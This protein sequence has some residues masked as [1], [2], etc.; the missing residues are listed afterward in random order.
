MLRR[1]QEKFNEDQRF[2]K[3]TY[4][5]TLKEFK[6]IQDSLIAETQ[7]NRGQNETSTL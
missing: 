2:L 1:R 5:K 4:E 7:A 3:E 6:T